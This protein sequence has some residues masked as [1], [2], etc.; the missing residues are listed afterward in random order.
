MKNFL[1]ST[2]MST[3]AVLAFAAGPAHAGEADLKAKLPA[4]IEDA[5]DQLGLAHGAGIA[6]VEGDR[7]VL[8]GGFGFADAKGGIKAT[9]RTSFYIASSTKSFTGLAALLLADEGRLDLDRSLAAWFPEISFDPAL[10]ADQITIRH[11]LSHTHGLKNGPIAYAAAYTGLHTP[12]TSLARLKD[13]TEVNTEAP[14]GTYDY[15]NLGYNIF[16]M[17][18]EREFGK[19]WQDILTEKVFSPAGM[20]HTSAYFSDAAAKGW[21][22]ALPYDFV[23]DDIREPLYLTKQDNTMHAAGGMIA[24]AH[25]IARFVQAQLSGGR[26]DGKQ[27]FPASTIEEAHKRLATFEETRDKLVRT[28]YGMGW[29]L[30]TFE[31]ERFTHHFGGFAGTSAHMSFLPDHNLGIVIL[32]NEGQA[33]Q[34][35]SRMI[36]GYAF[37][38]MRDKEGVDTARRAELAAFGETLQGHRDRI[39][40]H[41]AQNAARDWDMSLN[42]RQ[43]AGRYSNPQ[44]GTITVTHVGPKQ[45]HVSYGNMH[46]VATPYKESDAVRLEL[47]PGWGA[48]MRFQVT[49]K[50]VES[51]TYD[52]DIYVRD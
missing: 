14:F 1:K 25:D 37:D 29:I 16:S 51:L 34:P 8:E 11:L 22:L 13:H 31:G 38:M 26:I 42:F 6:V 21:S 17:I 30:G 20:T 47:V 24:S 4:F 19:P 36:A 27:V 12:A 50:T 44:Y 23:G 41:R 10:K 9:E 46:A 48:G 32:M 2:L 35:L 5:F 15:T 52:G 49:G 40:N 43:Y 7:I 45:L 3:A 39:A 33:S 28:G 18:L